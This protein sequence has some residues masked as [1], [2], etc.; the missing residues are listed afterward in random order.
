MQNGQFAIIGCRHGHIGMFIAEMMALGYRCA[1]IYEAGEPSLA[2]QLSDKFDIPVTG[3]LESL[4]APE[5]GMVGSSAVNCE[6]IDWIELCEQHGKPIMLDKPIVTSREGLNRLEA[7]MERG[8]IQVGM[9]LTS[10]DR[11]SIYTLKRHMDAGALGN[12]V[13]I[14]M[15][16]PHRL[17]PATRQPWH[18]AKLENGGIIVDLLIHDFDLLR[19]LTG[20]EV[21]GTS[22]LMAKHILPEYPDFYDTATV[23]VRLE[24]GILAQL[25]TDWHTPD[26]CWAFGDCRIFVS[27]TKGC[28]ELRLFG[29]PSVA[30]AAG[31]ELMF[32]MTNEEKFHRVELIQPPVSVVEDFIRRTEGKPHLV[33]HQDLYLACRAT[34]EADEQALVIK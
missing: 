30:S 2:R 29:D 20:R 9:L 14:T 28:A 6:K 33:T 32:T 24:G 27:G 12:I 19:W 16:K 22:G 23:Q 21:E 8:V 11:S 3:D 7:V 18:F 26:T 13:S 17:A 34:L 31:D 4:L 25:Y 5:I 15:R 10:R 1:G